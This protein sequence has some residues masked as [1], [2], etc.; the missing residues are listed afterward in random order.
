MVDDADV[1][2]NEDGKIV[3]KGTIVG[4]KSSPVLANLNEPVS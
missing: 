1:Q 4:G 2:A 3:P